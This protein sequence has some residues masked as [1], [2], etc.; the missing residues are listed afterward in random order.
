MSNQPHQWPDGVAIRRAGHT[1][2]GQPL[3]DFHLSTT[4]ET[5]RLTEAR[6]RSPLLPDSQTAWT[7]NSIINDHYD[8]QIQLRSHP[9]LKGDKI[10]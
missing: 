6:T 3:Y 9:H 8:Q 5:R 2:D 10:P 4:Q 1:E 7:L